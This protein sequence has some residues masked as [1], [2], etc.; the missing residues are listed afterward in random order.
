NQHFIYADT[1]ENKIYKENYSDYKQDLHEK[2]LELKKNN[3]KE[4]SAPPKLSTPEPKS[5]LSFKE[6]QEMKQIESE[7][8][9][10]EST[11]TEKTIFLSRLSDHEELLVASQEIENIQQTL[12]KKEER[13][14]SLLEKDNSCFTWNVLRVPR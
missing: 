4:V 3:G 1:P 13:Y 5:V 11:L 6:K 8:E 10:L 12:L 7:I 14:F 9:L 2:E